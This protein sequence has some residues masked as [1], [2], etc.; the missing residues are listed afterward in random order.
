MFNVTQSS[1]NSFLKNNKINVDLLNC[2]LLLK[3]AE[4]KNKSK[5]LKWTLD[6]V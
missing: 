6:N 3:N 5:F 2:V 1:G 4:S